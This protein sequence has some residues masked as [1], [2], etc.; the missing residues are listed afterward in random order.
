MNETPVSPGADRNRAVPGRARASAAP[1]HAP[2]ANRDRYGTVDSAG[3]AIPQAKARA[4]LFCPSGIFQSLYPRHVHAARGMP[5][6]ISRLHSQPGRR[7]PAKQD[8]DTDGHLRG[9]RPAASHDLM[10]MLARNSDPL[11]D[12]LLGNT[13]I[14]P[15]DGALCAITALDILLGRS[16][17]GWV[18]A[19]RNRR[20]VNRRARH[21]PA[22]CW[23][24]TLPAGRR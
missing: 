20:G 4:G 9:E 18:A 17:I 7:T 19:L 2:L 5:C 8:R 14:R 24:R 11:R 3:G 23:P 10:Q 1:R 12:I 16:L 21:I 6:V 22:R 15:G 13:D